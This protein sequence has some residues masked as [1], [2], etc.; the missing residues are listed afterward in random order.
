MAIDRRTAE[1]ALQSNLPL[2]EFLAGPDSGF[3]RGGGPEIPLYAQS[4]AFQLRPSQGF[5]AAQV[6]VLGGVSRVLQEAVIGHGVDGPAGQ[7][8][9]HL[10]PQLGTGEGPA[11]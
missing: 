5:E 7:D 2:P 3:E 10:R 8:L 1:A 9:H 11:A 4:V 6:P